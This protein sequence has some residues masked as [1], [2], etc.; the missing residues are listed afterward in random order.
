MSLLIKRNEYLSLLP[1]YDRLS[2]IVRSMCHTSVCRTQIE[3]KFCHLIES[4]SVH[5]NIL[6]SGWVFVNF[7]HCPNITYY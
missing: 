3:S 6:D 5:I 7:G 4:I 2:L 1:R